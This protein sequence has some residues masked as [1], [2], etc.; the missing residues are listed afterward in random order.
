VSESLS[1][2]RDAT[3]AKQNLLAAVSSALT[4]YDVPEEELFDLVAWAL[5]R[6]A[7]ADLN[8][9]RELEN[10]VLLAQPNVSLARILVHKL[11][12]SLSGMAAWFLLDQL[13]GDLQI[14]L[15]K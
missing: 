9:V 7:D 5:L 2:D 8:I 1:K 10:E 3:V 12:E 14:S 4:N 6:I 13:N 11:P 15:K